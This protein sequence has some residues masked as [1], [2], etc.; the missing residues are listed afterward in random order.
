MSP[1]IR[2]ATRADLPAIVRLFAS[3]DG[4][5]RDQGQDRE[6]LDALDPAYAAALDAIAGDPDNLLMVA[7]LGGDVVGVFQLTMT[8]L[9]A[10][11][12]GRVAE[13]EA[14]FVDPA[15]RGR[16][17]GGA[18]MRWAIDEARR[19]GCFRLQLTSNKKRT[20]A[21]AFYERLGFVATHEGM[22]LAL[23]PAPRR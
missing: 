22:K 9:V 23:S 4:N 17:V 16:G 14:V 1:I 7:E 18:M 2:A 20:R 12:G 6:A 8:Q 5:E 3:Q 15:V 19:R 21:H 11:R 10:H 13:V